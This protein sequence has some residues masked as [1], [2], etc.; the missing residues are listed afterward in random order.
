MIVLPSMQMTNWVSSWVSYLANIVYFRAKDTV[1]SRI[2]P[3]KFQA[4]KSLTFQIKCS[5]IYKAPE[6]QKKRQDK[7]Y[8]LLIHC[9]Q[10]AATNEKSKKQI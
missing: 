10:T 4:G 1:E 5:N 8:A 9:A 7:L 2:G 3:N 6:L